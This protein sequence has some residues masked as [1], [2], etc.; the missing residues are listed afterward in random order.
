MRLVPILAGLLSSACDCG[1]RAHPAADAAPD[2]QLDASPDPWPDAGPDAT[3][4]AGRGRPHRWVLATWSASGIRPPD[5]AA[6]AG[7]T[8]WIRV[9]SISGDDCSAAGPVVVEPGPA[10]HE[11]L[12][13]AHVWQVY[14]RSCQAVEVHESRWARLG[15]LEEG[16]WTVRDTQSEASLT[17]EVGPATSC[18]EAAAAERCDDDCDCGGA[19]CFASEGNACRG[20]CGGGPCDATCGTGRCFDEQGPD[21]DCRAHD[22]P[23]T[24]SGDCPWSQGCVEGRC[25]WLWRGQAPIACADGTDCPRGWSCVVADPDSE[26]TCEVRCL[27]D[28]TPCPTGTCHGPGWV[29]AE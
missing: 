27:T 25:T 26:G 28:R 7:R 12:L 1:F 13:T 23:C 5:C 2:A 4:D 10:A 29:C 21:G 24:D 16:T 20:T 6:A 14:G 22:G 11:L 18:D 15:P 8:V 19:T 17:F 3:V 9:E